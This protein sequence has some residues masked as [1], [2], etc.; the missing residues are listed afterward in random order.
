M[1]H[2]VYSLFF[3]LFFFFYFFG[4]V[5]Y[6]IFYPLCFAGVQVFFIICAI[7]QINNIW[8][9]LYITMLISNLSPFAGSL[10]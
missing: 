10:V 4:Q 9:L 7:L 1:P 8:C 3:G 6:E 2:I 5:T